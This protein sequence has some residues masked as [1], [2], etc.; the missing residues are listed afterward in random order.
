MN[1][2]MPCNIEAEQATLGAILLSGHAIERVSQ[3]LTPEDFYR[4]DHSLIYDSMLDLYNRHEE[5]DIITVTEDLDKKHL[6]EKA[7]GLS[8]VTVLGG[9][10]PTAVNVMYYAKI[11]LE[12][13]RLRHIIRHATTV[14]QKAQNLDE[15]DDINAYINQNLV[16]VGSNDEDKYEVDMPSTVV[17]ILD[18][19]DRVQNGEDVL[20]IKTG[21]TALDEKIKGLKETDYIILAARPSMGK[22]ALALDIA[23]NV[24]EQGKH[25]AFF[26]LEMS[27]KSLVM[28][29]LSQNSKVDWHGK[30]ADEEWETLIKAGHWIEKLPLHLFEHSCMRV[31]D[32][33]SKCRKLKS[34]NKLDLV[35][36]DYLQ[37]IIPDVKGQKV[38]SRYLEV[39]E[40]SKSLKLLAKE[41]NIPVLCLSQ[42]NRG[43]ESRND[44]RPGPAD[45]RESG[46]LEQDADIILM[47]Y[48][49]EYYNPESEKAGIADII[50]AKHRN[51]PVGTIELGFDPECT[52]FYNIKPSPQKELVGAKASKIETQEA[53]ELFNN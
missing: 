46:A 34:Q 45:L 30:M 26:S 39:S 29:S 13:S 20:G 33:V 2:Q 35:I 16:G 23:L 47:I 53:Q 49:D 22:S 24:M 52:D 14:I 5:I 10:V 18:Y 4:M 42:L 6:L 31:S 25:V 8:L 36:I 48:R 1:N 51:G 19:I 11:V 28:R 12:K 9:L 3:I 41:L 44:K 40:I 37:L 7:G 43:V 50:I 27:A 17:D 15:L 32:I 38:E 21:F